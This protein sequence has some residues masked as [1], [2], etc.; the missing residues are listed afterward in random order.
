MFF[1]KFRIN[2]LIWDNSSKNWGSKMVDTSTEIGQIYKMYNTPNTHCRTH[3]IVQNITTNPIVFM[4]FWSIICYVD[5]TSLCLVDTNSLLPYVDYVAA[6]LAA[7]H[8]RLRFQPYFSNSNGFDN[9]YN[10]TKVW[11]KN[12]KLL[13]LAAFVLKSRQKLCKSVSSSAH[14]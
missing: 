3:I 14:K 12:F 8:C 5:F 1:Y 10:L 2:I 6:M 13:F 4:I 11:E 9:M 7:T